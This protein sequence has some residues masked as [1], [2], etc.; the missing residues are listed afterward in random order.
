MYVCTQPQD[1]QLVA[2]HDPYD[3]AEMLK[4]GMYAGKKDLEAGNA[5]NEHTFVNFPSLEIY[6]KLLLIFS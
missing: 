6:N 5:K 1:N 3:G 4:Y 2:E